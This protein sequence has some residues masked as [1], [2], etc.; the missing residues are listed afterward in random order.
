MINGEG[1]GGGIDVSVICNVGAKRIIYYLLV[2]NLSYIF[3]QSSRHYLMIYQEW[4]LLMELV[5]VPLYVVLLDIEHVQFSMVMKTKNSMNIYVLDLK[6]NKRTM[7]DRH[8]RQ[9]EKGRLF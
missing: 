8:R 2:I 4:I 9:E 1:G 5:L 3:E 6:N 7:I